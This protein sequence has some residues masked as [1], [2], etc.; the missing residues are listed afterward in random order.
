MSSEGVVFSKKILTKLIVIYKEHPVLWKIKSKEYTNKNL[1]TKAYN[2]LIEYSKLSYPDAD[3]NFVSKKIQNIRECFRKELKK[4]EAS[5]MSGTGADDVYEP[6]LWYF[7]LLLFTTDQEMPVESVDSEIQ[8]RSTNN[9]NRKRKYPQ[10]QQ[11]QEFMKTCTEVLQ[12]KKTVDEFDAVSNNV[13]AK[14]RKMVPTQQVLAEGLNNKVLMKGIFNE[15][16]RATEISNG[17]TNI[18]MSSGFGPCHICNRSS[19]GCKYDTVQ[20]RKTF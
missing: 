20:T 19:F 3:R 2:A 14:L 7:D 5:Q 13:A 9:N 10:L 1:K 8:F 18:R 4:V 17:F 11:Q 15:L 16:T 6:H 12:Q